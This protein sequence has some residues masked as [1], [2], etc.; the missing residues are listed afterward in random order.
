[1]KLTF[2]LI[3]LLF[4][5]LCKAQTKKETED[6]IVSK[7]AKY[8]EINYTADKQAGSGASSK[9]TSIKLSDCQLEVIE[10]NEDHRRDNDGKKQNFKS[11]NTIKIPIHDLKEIS[12]DDS[13]RQLKFETNKNTISWKVIDPSFPPNNETTYESFIFFK[14]NLNTEENLYN[15]LSKAFDHLRKNYCS[16]SNAKTESF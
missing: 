7:L 8:K 15:R 16:K 1:M 14:I 10:T 2:T 11:T 12:Y 13:G 9:L 4:S 6:W 3:S 5:L